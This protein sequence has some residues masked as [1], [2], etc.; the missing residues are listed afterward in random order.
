MARLTCASKKWSL[1]D[2]RTCE[3][4]EEIL[5]CAACVP[6]SVRTQRTYKKRVRTCER[7][8]AP[9]AADWL[10]R[11]ACPSTPNIIAT[12]IQYTNH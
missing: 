11:T 8:L 9:A 3:A 2:T 1:R 4:E 12:R 7:Q 10:M 6:V 5:A